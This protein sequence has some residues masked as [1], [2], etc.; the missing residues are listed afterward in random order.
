MSNCCENFPDI[1]KHAPI[2]KGVLV[3]WLW[4]AP[5][6]LVDVICDLFHAAEYYADYHYCIAEDWDSFVY[7]A[8]CELLSKGP[9]V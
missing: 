1:E 8:M 3:G 2:L 9:R 4:D 7:G 6:P 5:A